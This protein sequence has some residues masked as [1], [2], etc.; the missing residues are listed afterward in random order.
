MKR[1][2]GGAGSGFDPDFYRRRY[3]DL[4]GL[5]DRQALSHYEIHG[6]LEGRKPNDK[7]RF[8]DSPL[9]ASL[10]PLFSI[11][12][13]RQLNPDVDKAIEDDWDVYLHYI[14][15]GRDEGRSFSNLDP[16][17]YSQT[18]MGAGPWSD[19]EIGAHFRENETKGVCASFPEFLNANNAK[20][21]VWQENF[22]DRAFSLLNFDWL[23][24][25]VEGVKAKV[26][27]VTEGI[28]RLAD[29]SFTKRFDLAFY[30]E[31]H[32]LL[33]GAT[34]ETAYRHWLFEGMER[35]EPGSPKE[36]MAV[37]GLDLLAYPQ[38]F[39][40]T[41]YAA[42]HLESRDQHNRWV[43]LKHLLDH[44]PMGASTWP[45]LGEDAESFLLSIARFRISK[46]DYAAAIGT[47][48]RAIAMGFETPAISHAMGDAYHGL[49]LWG[50]AS[51]SYSRA[52]SVSDAKLWS[53]VLGAESAAKAGNTADALATLLGT[54][55]EFGGEQPWL[56]I[57]DT[58]IAQ[59][60][61][62][63]TVKARALY[64]VERRAEGDEVMEGAVK[65]ISDAFEQGL[66]FPT[67]IGNKKKKVVILANTSLDQCTF[68]RVDQKRYF[69]EIGGWDYEI[70][71]W[72]ED[73]KF[74]SAIADASAC[75]FYRVPAFPSIIRCILQA[76]RLGLATYYEI[77][78]LIFD[79]E[80]YPDSFESFQGQIDRGVYQGLIY[81]TTL[82][83]SAMRLC[84]YG[85]ASTPIL[86]SRMGAEVESKKC[87]VVRN[88]LDPRNIFGD[89]LGARRRA[90]GV[91]RIVYGSATLA[92]NQDFHDI[93]GQAIRH[94]LEA[95]SHVELVVVGHLALDDS[96]SPY[97][98][99]I[100]KIDLIKDPIAYWSLLSTMDINLA[101][102]ASG[103]MTD[104]KSEIKWLEAAVLGVPSVVS[105]TA[106]Y[107]EVVEDGVTG[108]IAQTP[109]QWTAR[110]RMLVEDEACR[111]RIGEAAREHVLRSYSAEAGAMAMSEA[112]Q[113]AL[114]VQAASGKKRILLV[115]VF[116]PPQSIG[117]ATRVVAD[118]LHHLSASEEFTFAV[119][120]TDHDARPNYRERLDSFDGTNVFRIAPPFEDNLDWKY[121][122]K[123]M[124]EWFSRVVAQF[125]PDL[126]HFHC[127]QRITSSA[128]DV[129]RAKDVPYIVSVH[130]GWWLSDYQFL[131]DEKARMRTPGDE[132]RLGPKPPLRL[133]D[134]LQRLAYLRNALE[135]AKQVLTPSLN[136]EKIYVDAGFTN[137]STLSNGLPKV[138]VA[139][140]TRSRS[141]RV[142]LAHIG[143][144]S[145][146]KG[147][148]L[149]EAALRQ[150]EFENLE[151]LALSHGLPDTLKSTV[152]WGKTEVT[153]SGR[154]RQ[155]A[156]PNLYANI[157]VLLAPSACVESYGLVT[158]EAN[159]A[160]VWVVASDRGAIGEDVRPGIDG[161][162]VDVTS[163]AALSA[164]LATINSDPETYLRPAPQNE[165]VRS[166]KEQA[167][168]LLH[169]YS[170]LTSERIDYLES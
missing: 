167:D 31:A 71:E 74:L 162:I 168:H 17:F 146:H 104:C 99:R 33:A 78:D 69:F 41:E 76:R 25:P 156:V 151:L 92:H 84:E 150:G 149:V 9:M 53:V 80:N 16:E 20:Y 101:V 34:P 61:Q 42:A 11:G 96:F 169:I 40:W 51:D 147:F 28:P 60:F 59:E 103:L 18:Y 3:S 81:G 93:A 47:L 95:F 110:L 6:G 102:L 135:G 70:V 27:F 83:R 82:Y 75:I 72:S 64:S 108:L 118:N 165:A 32:P 22:S 89:G 65:W 106:T 29:F 39:V 13:Y 145:P 148:D 153:F 12:Q 79:T 166:S 143:D 112:L 45:V 87:F 24:G 129:C 126:V 35:G 97:A 63:A 55:A 30:R 58:V 54:K 7:A 8:E 4:R 138:A 164:V 152:I 73:E 38:A 100:I 62:D 170:R 114:P 43:A 50:A 15:H 26:L 88:G 133:S 125:E 119:A 86:A 46:H 37:H 158:R 5:S 117:G 90:D 132:I 85:I 91:V 144:T 52:K 77:D 159:A 128:I 139:P 155:A 49:G 10:P 107:N 142:R 36:W 163:P 136:F 98:D 56:T 123:R 127:I 94:V 57:L 48:Q 67:N 137:V 68:Y 19:A 124:E 121:S 140:R 122:D 161:F 23:G 111:H 154:I 14:R 134:S 141:G 2:P 66:D 1:N 120:T 116:F 115:N 131:F 160:G 21:I 113:P 157:D 44:D 130:D 105:A 109:E